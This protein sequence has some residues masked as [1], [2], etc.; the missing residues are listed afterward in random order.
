MDQLP[1]EVSQHAQPF[2]H[3]RETHWTDV[4]RA[5]TSC[6]QSATY[7]P[8]PC[9][10]HSIHSPEGDICALWAVLV[11]SQSHMVIRCRKHPVTWHWGKLNMA[12]NI[13]C[14]SLPCYLIKSHVTVHQES[15]TVQLDDRWMDY[16]QKGA[17]R[18][19]VCLKELQLWNLGFESWLWP[20]LSEPYFP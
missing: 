1:R 10:R 8:F 12:I 19:S 16:E 14:G 4:S 20:D 2:F 3:L 11:K 5:I 17:V 13:L 6:T 7:R 18:S 15:C 9:L